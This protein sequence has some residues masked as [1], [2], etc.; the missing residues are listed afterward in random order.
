MPTSDEVFR[1]AID[2]GE[3]VSSALGL[4]RYEVSVLRVFTTG[5]RPGV[6]TSTSFT[7]SVKVGP[8]ATGNP[9]LQQMSAREVFL[10]NG[11]YSDQSYILGPFVDAY[12]GSCGTGG[13]DIS[14]FK[15]I[16][17]LSSSIHQ[18][19]YVKVQGPG[20]LP[21]GSLFSVE[22]IEQDSSLSYTVHIKHTGERR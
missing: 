1:R 18:Q 13:T 5:S 20:M 14:I 8:G 3:G 15:P 22:R 2:V 21:S 9:R 17:H 6:G 4:R 11:T 7:S 16:P 10:S 19:L 12:S